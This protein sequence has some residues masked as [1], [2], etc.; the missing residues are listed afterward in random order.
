MPR[1]SVPRV[2]R[3]PAPEGAGASEVSGVPHIGA[4]DGVIHERMR[5]AIVHA[6]ASRTSL[7]FGELK[8][9]LSM[10]DGNLSVH[11]RRLEEVGYIQSRK[12]TTG[13]VSRTEFSLA[14]AG[15]RALVRYLDQLEAIVSTLRAA[16]DQPSQEKPTL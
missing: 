9:L 5:L 14:P 12:T 13:R 1:R 10:T 16:A 11:A 6:L 8:H 3:P 7:T 15:R 4:L 2:T